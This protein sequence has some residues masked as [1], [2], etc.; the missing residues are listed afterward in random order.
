MEPNTT[1]KSSSKDEREPVEEKPAVEQPKEDQNAGGGWGWGFSAFS[2]LSD[3]QKAAEEIS[4]NAAEVAKTAANSIS[5]LQNELEG[6]ESSKEDQDHQAASDKDQESED[7]DDKKRKATLERLEKASED[8][9][10][11]QGIKAIDSSVENFASG[12]WQALGNAWKGGSSFV[13]KLEDS[14]QQGGIP[15]AGSVAPSLLETGRAFTAKGLQVLEYV[16]K[17][18]VD[19]LIAESGMEV[20]KNGGEGGHG[21]EEDQLLEE[22]TFDRCFYIYG[23]PEHLEELEALSNHYALLFNRRKAKLSTDEKSAYDVKLKEVQQ[24]LSLD[25]ESDGKN[26][27]SE[28][29]KNVENSSDGSYDE[30][31]SFHGSSVS[32]AAEMATGFANALAGLSPSDIALRTGG[33]LDSLHSEGIHRLSEMCCIAVSQLV[34]LGKS[35]VKNANKDDDVAKFD[36]PEDCIEKAKTIRTK[37]QSMTGFVEA[38]AIS[39]V[40]GISDVAEAYAAAIKSATEVLPEKVIEEKVKSFSEDLRVNRTTAVAKIQD[41]LHFLAYVILSTSMPAAT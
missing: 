15:A 22:V 4:R 7:E 3:L 27:E 16:G 8:T 21:T 36:W 37:T 25:T 28:K 20:D 19:L 41:G 35:V 23:G 33:R 10:L 40:T 13:Q 39:F 5:E 29:G 2:V 34:A 12:A 31:K 32:K 26:A 17:E 1:I 6:S 9:I 11:G 24:L 30:I 18:T 14:I 38:V